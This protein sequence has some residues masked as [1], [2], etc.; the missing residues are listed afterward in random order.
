MKRIKELLLLG[1]IVVL[2]SISCN[3]DD[4]GFVD[5][6]DERD[7][8]MGSWNVTET[9]LKTNFNVVITKDPNNSA[10]LLLA[11]FGNPGPGYA[12]T[13]GLV[14]GNKIFVSN[15]TIGDGWTVSGTGTLQDANTISWT[16]TL[17]IAGDSFSCTSVFSK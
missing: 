16:Y 3:P 2:G 14:A 7:K 1:L 5:P 15:Q 6:G 12:P 13:I 11:N 4:D 8:F 10:Q 17:V 9:C